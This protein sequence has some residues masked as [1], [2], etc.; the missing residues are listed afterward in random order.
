MRDIYE[1][2]LSG[3]L[4]AATVAIAISVLHREFFSGGPTGERRITSEFV[5]GW[6]KALPVARAVGPARAPITIVEFSDLECPFC[7]RFQRSMQALRTKFP[8]KISYF[9][10]HFPLPAHEHALAAARAAECAN[11]VGRFPEAI[12][13]LFA[14]QDS[15][16]KRSW[17]WFGQGA[18]VN[19]TV[20]F[21]RCVSDTLTPPAVLAGL[22]LGKQMNVSATPTV[23]INGWRYGVVPADSELARA[24]G[25]LLAGRRPYHGYPKAALTASR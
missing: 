22:D 24:V 9:F 2:A 16:G 18:G 17:G 23:F 5:P 3:V 10:V 1:R 13:F 8:N 7:A 20:A 12:D 4:I 11:A 6:Q 14:N 21:S 15:L 19:D 25:D